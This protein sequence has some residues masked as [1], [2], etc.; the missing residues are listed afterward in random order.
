[1]KLPRPT[2]E[3]NAIP[4]LFI[5]QP[6]VRV[7]HQHPFPSAWYSKSLTND[8]LS[9]ELSKIRTCIWFSKEPEPVPSALGPSETAACPSSPTAGNPSAP[10]SPTSSPSSSQWLF[11]PVDS[12]PA[13]MCLP[14]F[15]T[16]VLLKVVYVRLKYFLC[17]VFAYFLC[18]ICVKSIIKLL[19]YST[20]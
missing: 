13:P 11:S 17:F 2:P 7:C 8:P 4:L 5:C 9:C 19:Q 6:R 14:L 18:I 10:P 15:C 12:M 1:M 20:I 16:T 3:A